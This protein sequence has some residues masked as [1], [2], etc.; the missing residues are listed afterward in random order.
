MTKQDFFGYGGARKGAMIYRGSYYD[1]IA[2]ADALGIE[3]SVGVDVGSRSI[4]Y[5]G[6]L[7]SLAIQK[8][9]KDLDN[10]DD[11]MAAVTKW[12]ELEDKGRDYMD[13]H[14]DE[15]DQIV[16]DLDMIMSDYAQTQLV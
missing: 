6:N 5:K 15:K 16:T 12:N 8:L 1:L 3:L 4:D 13:A 10:N 7:N 14:E 2:E 9:V 11:L